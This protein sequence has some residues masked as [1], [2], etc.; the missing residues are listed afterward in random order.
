MTPAPHAAPRDLA[1]FTSSPD[2]LC[3]SAVPSMSRARQRAKSTARV[4]RISTTLIC[5]GYCSSASM[6]ARDLLARAGA[7][8]RRRSASGVTM[9]RT[10]RP[11]WIAIHLLHAAVARRDRL[12]P[13]SRFTYVSN[14]SRRAPGREPEIASAACTSTE[15]RSRA[16]R[17]RG[18]RRCSSRPR[19][20]AVLR[21][22]LH[23]E[24]HVRALVLVRE[25]LADVVQQRAALAPSATSSPSSAAMMPASHATSFECSRMF[26]P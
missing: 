2:R 23:A 18:A 22:H 17:R 12:E 6:R 13:L 10:S 3:R 20:L 16:A 14:A 7:M 19:V 4:S 25:H 1:R 5:P 8:R 11:A 26:W 21:R 24:L 15:T 9:T